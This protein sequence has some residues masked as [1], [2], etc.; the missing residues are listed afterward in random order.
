MNNA[1]E[2]ALRTWRPKEH[3]LHYDLHHPLGKLV[4]EWGELLD[5][6]MKWQYK[7]GYGKLA[8]LPFEPLNELIDIWYYIRILSYQTNVSLKALDVANTKLDYLISVA[9]AGISYEFKDFVPKG[10]MSPSFHHELICNYSYV[11]AICDQSDLTINQLTE[12]SW[13]KLKPGSVR[14]DEWVKGKNV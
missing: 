9:I 3:S 2:L 12:A 13:E 5:D 14:G 11:I 1:I 8:G 6:Y 7:P 4:G 10:K